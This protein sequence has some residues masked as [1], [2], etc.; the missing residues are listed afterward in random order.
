MAWIQI[1]TKRREATCGRLSYKIVE[2]DELYE[3]RNEG[4]GALY[5]TQSISDA[6]GWIIRHIG[7]NV[8]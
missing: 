5:I 4:T 1:D 2:T 8:I 6:W 3:V 7:D